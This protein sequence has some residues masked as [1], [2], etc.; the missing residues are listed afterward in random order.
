MRSRYA[1]VLELIAQGRTVTKDMV[2]GDPADR[3]TVWLAD[4]PNQAE[5]DAA[6]A[7]AFRDAAEAQRQAMEGRSW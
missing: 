2:T 3:G 7:A 6:Q 5:I 1:A 4:E